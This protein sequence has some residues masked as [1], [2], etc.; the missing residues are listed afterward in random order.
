MIQIAVLDN[1]RLAQA[2]IDYLATRQIEITMT[3]DENNHF[4]LWLKDPT[5]QVEVNHEFSQFIA[6]PN[7]EKYAA[8]SWETGST[9]QAFKYQSPNMLALIKAKAGVVTLGIM[10]ICIVIYLL[11]SLGFGREIFTSLHFPAY[12]DQKWQ[13]W[14]WVTHALLHF[15]ITHIAFNLMWW[16]QI[17]GDIEKRLGSGK[18]SLIFLLSAAVSG[19]VQYYVGGANF[20]GLSGVVYALL[21][22]AWILGLKAP[23]FGLQVP[24]TIVI[25]MLGWLALGFV[26]PLMAIANFAH[27]AGLVVGCALGLLDAW[28]MAD[29]GAKNKS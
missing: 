8:A 5:H 27:L 19:A 7:D 10:L 17:G 12:M 18:L 3:Q 13:L 28:R 22:Y 20:G 16:W 15:S 26:Q 23:Q 9:S 1:P 6:N 11:Q 24:K 29:H 25:F 4:V 21:G 14:R 2:F